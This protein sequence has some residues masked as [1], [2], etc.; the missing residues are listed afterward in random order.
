MSTKRFFVNLPGWFLFLSALA[1]AQPGKVTIGVDVGTSIIQR[2]PLFLVEPVSYGFDVYVYSD[3]MVPKNLR[4]RIELELGRGLALRFSAGYGFTGEKLQYFSQPAGA[5]GGSGQF[6]QEEKFTARGFPLEAALLLKYPFQ[7]F[8]V[9]FGVVGGFYSYKFKSEGF[10]ESTGNADPGQN[11]RRGLTGE[12]LKISGFAQSFLMGVS[13]Q[14]SAKLE[15]A[16]EI[17]KLGY[18]RLQEKQ[19]D[20]RVISSIFDPLPAVMARGTSRRDYN[21]GSGLEDIALSLGINL[22]MGNK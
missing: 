15:A 11:Y 16:F 6:R 5:T 17:S 9:H 22:K 3:E 2:Q 10:S 13:L 18:S 1:F 14:I 7:K 4:G 8:G 21:A 20:Q 12:E 19:N